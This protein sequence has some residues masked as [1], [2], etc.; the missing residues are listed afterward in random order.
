[1]VKLLFFCPHVW[2]LSI[3]SIMKVTYNLQIICLIDCLA[4]WFILMMYN[5]MNVKETGQY[6][7]HIANLMGLGDD[8]CFHWKDCHN[9]KP[10]SHYQY[11]MDFMKSG[12]WLVQSSMSWVISMPSCFCCST[13]TL[14]TN[15]TDT[16]CKCSIKIE[17]TDPVLPPTL[18]AISWIVTWWSSINYAPNLLSQL[19]ISVLDGLIEHASLATEVQPFWS[20][21]TSP[22]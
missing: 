3:H 12:L 8:K 5:T 6:Y 21:C 13:C 19:L 20:G 4:L 1:M 14:W 10:M 22:W 11:M 7:P 2:P 15:F 18:W 17:Y 16:L 9:P